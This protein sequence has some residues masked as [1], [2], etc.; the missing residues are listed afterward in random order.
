M[1]TKFTM[2]ES[3]SNYKSRIWEK[4]D[5]THQPLLAKCLSTAKRQVHCTQRESQNSLKPFSLSSF[6]SVLHKHIQITLPWFFSF[7]KFFVAGKNI[8]ISSGT[9][10]MTWTAHSAAYEGKGKRFI[11]T[12]SGQPVLQKIPTKALLSFSSPNERRKN[13]EVRHQIYYILTGQDFP[14]YTISL[15]RTLSSAVPLFMYY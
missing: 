3:I 8:S 4:W 1:E 6:P 5:L 13:K 10:L 12:K 9:F 11:S 2:K 14:I 15:M 7:N